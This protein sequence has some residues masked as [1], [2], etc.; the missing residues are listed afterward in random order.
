MVTVNDYDLR[1][2]NGD[3]GIVLPDPEAD[4]APQ[5]FF[6]AEDGG[7]RKLPAARLPAHETV[8][9]MTVHKSQGSEFGRVLLI[10]PDRETEILTRELVYTAVTRASVRVQVMG[11]AEVFK[12]AVSRRVR[13]NSGL[14]ERLWG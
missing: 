5:V 13:R 2:F 4:G 6:P 1:L 3:I 10:L 9:A 14:R 11:D 8:Y 7:I 12:G